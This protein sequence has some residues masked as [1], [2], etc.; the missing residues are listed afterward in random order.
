LLPSGKNLPVILSVPVGASQPNTQFT[1]SYAAPTIT[2]VLAGGVSVL[3]NGFPTAGTTVTVLG[4][5]LGG[6]VVFANAN[7]GVPTPIGTI[8]GQSSFTLT[9]A[10]QTSLTAVIPAGD[11]A[12]LQVRLI[13]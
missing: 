6:S 3:S 2:D 1:F 8:V 4:T 7:D 11:G 5:N 13:T 9:P 10:T 12:N